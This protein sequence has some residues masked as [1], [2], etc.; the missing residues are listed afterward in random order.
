[1]LPY[2]YIDG[3]PFPMYVVMGVTGFAVAMLI[4]LI[5]R[6]AF[7]LRIR[8]VIQ[9][10]VFAAIG[11]LG[12]ARVLG[13]IVK[14]ARL[15]S[16]PGFW[17]A[18][19]LFDVALKSGWV[20]Y[21]GLLGGFGMIVLLAKLKRV[22]MKIMTN[23]YA[24]AAL[25]FVSFARFGCYC[26]GCC[27]GI[28]LTD[29]TKFPVQLIESGFCFVVLLAFLVVRPERRWPS[30]PLFPVYAIIYSAERFIL[31]FF[32]G[33]ASRGVWLLSTSQ[34]IALALITLAVIWL[35]KSGF[36]FRRSKEQPSPE[37]LPSLEEEVALRN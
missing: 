34:W 25:A 18:K 13:V 24:Y 37:Q 23:A 35:K 11:I 16:N 1:M 29:G 4:V 9:F 10:S 12:G 3:K 32:R 8:D 28:T 27:Y 19:N 2:V 15:G 33:D 21:G 22:D 6:R 31:E 17:T 7:S 20:F 26:A 5:K 36:I 14:M 30:L